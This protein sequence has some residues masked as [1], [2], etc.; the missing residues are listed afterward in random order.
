MIDGAAYSAAEIEALARRI[1]EHR[2]SV[3]LNLEGLE[4]DTAMSIINQMV[5]CYLQPYMIA[6]IEDKLS[7]EK[8]ALIVG[9]IFDGLNAKDGGAGGTQDIRAA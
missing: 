4:V 5:S 6:M 3:V 2:A 8:L 9:A 1:R 7:E